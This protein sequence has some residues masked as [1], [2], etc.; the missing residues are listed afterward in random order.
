MNQLEQAGQEG[1]RQHHA[2]V[3]RRARLGVGRHGGEH[4]DGNRRGGAGH[5]VPGGTEQG[6][7]D[8]G[9]HGRVDAV[10]RRQAGDGGEGHRLG[11]DDQ[12]AGDAGDAVVLEGVAVDPVPPF[13]EGQELVQPQVAGQDVGRPFGAEALV[14]QE[15]HF[16]SRQRR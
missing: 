11:Q 9:H 2:D 16:F 5:Q 14:F 8:G 1:E 13:Q 10:F 12:G 3:F 15:R 6:G 7:D 4:H